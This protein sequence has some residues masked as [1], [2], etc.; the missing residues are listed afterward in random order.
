MKFARLVCIAF[1][2]T[3]IAG[4]A[5]LS[6]AGDKD[7]AAAASAAHA[8]GACTAEMAAK[9]TPEMAAACKAKMTAAS[10]AHASG[11][12]TAEMAAKC[13]PEMAAA[14]KAKMTAAAASSPTTKATAVTASASG[15]C[16]MKGMKATAAA[17]AAANGAGSTKGM[18]ASAAAGQCN[19]HGMGAMAAMSAHDDCE[20]CLD[21]SSCSDA[22]D[23][24]G[25]HRQAVRLKNG[26][27]YVYTADSPGNVSAVQAAVARRGEHMAQLASAGDKA[28]L[29]AECKSMRGAMASGKLTREVVNIEGGSLTLITSTDR[30]V[31]AKIHAMTDQ[32]VAARTKS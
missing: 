21:M 24:A 10:A 17:T 13:T 22:L 8:S 6:F 7:K 5:T 9:C 25:A 2:V 26:V 20:A 28:R 19:S 14:C 16:N 12:C 29:C 27:M 3:M 18:G 4:W 31:V 15:A 1:A 30:A 32:K 23:D 11:A